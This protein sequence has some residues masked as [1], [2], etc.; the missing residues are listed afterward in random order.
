MDGF[1]ILDFLVKNTSSETQNVEDIIYSLEVTHNLEGSGFP[2]GA[3]FFDGFEKL[4]GPLEPN[5]EM[6]GKF[7]TFV[8]ESE[9]YYF[10]KDPGNIA[11]GS[12]NQ[13]IWT[14]KADEAR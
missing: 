13:V 2:D 11:A 9:E 10:R 7:I 5:E 1:I 8:Y 6:E 14:I 3:E 12:S 4:S